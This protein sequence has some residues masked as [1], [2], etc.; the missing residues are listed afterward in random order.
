[1]H[2]VGVVTV[3]APVPSSSIKSVQATKHSANPEGSLSVLI[4]LKD[5]VITQAVWIVR[6]DFV[7]GEIPS[8]H[9][10]FVGSSAK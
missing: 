6:I 3:M 1:M 4:Q 2:I 9:V 5:H 7:V 8:S 10:Q